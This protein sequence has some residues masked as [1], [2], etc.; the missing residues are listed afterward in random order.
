MWEFHIQ[1]KEKES[2]AEEISGDH[3]PQPLTTKLQ[4]HQFLFWWCEKL[5]SRLF[6]SV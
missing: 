4:N 1:I 3:L 6:Y 5:F 2:G